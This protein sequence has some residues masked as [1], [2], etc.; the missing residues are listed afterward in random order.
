MSRLLSRRRRVRALTVLAAGTLAT[1]VLAAGADGASASPRPAQ[2]VTT[3]AAR[4]ACATAQ[5]PGRAA[6]LA[7][8]RSG[9]QARAAGVPAT[10]VPVNR[11]ATTRAGAHAPPRPTRGY[12]AAD[13]KSIY[14]ID[15]RA[16]SG[17]TVAIVDAFDNPNAE[18]DLG[19]YRAVMGL[20]ACTTAN[21]CFRRVNQDGGTKPPQP[22]AGWGLEIAL[23]LQATSAACPRCRIL[24]VEAKDDFLDNLGLAVKRAV[25]LGAKIVSN[26]YGADEY[27]GA[28]AD[29]AKYYAAPGVAFVVS[30]GDFGFTAAAFPAVAPHAIAVGGTSVTKSRGSWVHHAWSGSGSGCSAWFAKPAWQKDPNCA[31]RTL[32]DLSALADPDT[33][34]AVYDTYG[35]G[36]DN[37]WI[38][39]GGT[40]LSAPLVAGMIGLAGNAPKLSD[41]SYIYAHT[42]GLRDVLGGSNGFCGEDYLCTAVLGYDGPTGL[43]TPKNGVSAL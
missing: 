43:G 36:P 28:I 8:W 27:N 25:A 14:G 20:P 39:V 23:D 11:T 22:D 32:A 7:R 3:P 10:S 2:A 40:S 16:G 1:G 29:A 5:R 41:A 19:V 21:G 42:S 13:V 17:Q 30:S 18:K 6:C 31:M 35:L 37:G 33:G 4:P 24:Q 38:V 9:P 26:S 34:L 12:G 15:T